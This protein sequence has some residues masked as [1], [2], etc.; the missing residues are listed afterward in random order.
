MKRQQCLTHRQRVNGRGWVSQTRTFSD[1]FAE[2]FYRPGIPQ[3]AFTFLRY[4]LFGLFNIYTRRT[5]PGPDPAIGLLS[6]AN[7]CVEDKRERDQR[8]GRDGRRRGLGQGGKES[9]RR[10]FVTCVQYAL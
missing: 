1:C 3:K 6:S 2:F 5:L 10:N 8:N 4:T 9:E 7:S